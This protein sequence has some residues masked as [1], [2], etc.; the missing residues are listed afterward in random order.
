METPGDTIHRISSLFPT[1][2]FGQPL[3]SAI[4]R[5]GTDLNLF[6]MLEGNQSEPLSSNGLARKTGADVLLMSMAC[7]SFLISTSPKLSQ[8]NS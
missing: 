8:N 3:Q 1:D 6:D 2:F 4:A 5:V 7:P